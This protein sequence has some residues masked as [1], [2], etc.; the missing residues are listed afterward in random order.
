MNLSVSDDWL[1]GFVSFDNQRKCIGG[2]GQA[3]K[4]YS[5]PDD[6]GQCDCASDESEK[7]RGCRALSFGEIG[8]IRVGRVVLDL[9]HV[10]FAKGSRVE[11]LPDR[12]SRVDVA[13][14]PEA[15]AEFCTSVTST[16]WF[17]EYAVEDSGVCPWPTLCAVKFES[18]LFEQTCQRQDLSTN[19]LLSAG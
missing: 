10:V 5:N 9:D 13:I 2:S 4:A 6:N 11:V 18:S 7:K 17:S 16:P 12:Y 8:F 3:E 19:I 1:F 14:D 15:V